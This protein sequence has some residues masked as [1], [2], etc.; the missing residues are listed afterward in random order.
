MRVGL[1]IVIELKEETEI[2]CWRN[3]VQRAAD[4]MGGKRATVFGDLPLVVANY[5]DLPQLA[6]ILLEWQNLPHSPFRKQAGAGVDKTR[7]HNGDAH[8]RK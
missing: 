8:C 3:I 7:T 1:V 5:S 6:Q 2:P 4:R